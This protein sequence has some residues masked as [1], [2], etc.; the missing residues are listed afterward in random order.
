MNLFI[1]AMSTIE[2]GA[3]GI[4]SLPLKWMFSGKAA[5]TINLLVKDHQGE[6]AQLGNSM[7]IVKQYPGTDLILLEVPRYK[8]FLNC[9]HV[10]TNTN[11]ELIEVAGQKEI[12][13]TVAYSN[14]QQLDDCLALP[15]C[16]YKYDW[17]VPTYS[18]T[19]AALIVP[20]ASLKLVLQN[21]AQRNVDIVYIHDF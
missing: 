9:M 10:L 18:L 15:G 19:H 12:Q 17:Q 20:V 14:R 3:K 8:E 1:G 21:L 16:S 7:K 6:A 11:I 2:Y 5:T 4:V 13:L